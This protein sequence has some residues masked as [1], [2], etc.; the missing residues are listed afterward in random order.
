MYTSKRQAGCQAAIAGKPRSYRV[1]DP[2][3]NSK[4]ILPRRQLSTRAT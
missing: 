2:D 3:M 4:R 1:R